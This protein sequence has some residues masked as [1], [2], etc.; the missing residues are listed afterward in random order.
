MN[1]LLVGL[2]L[3][4][5]GGFAHSATGTKM[6]CVGEEKETVIYVHLMVKDH[7]NLLTVR[8]V[9]KPNL[10]EV[11]FDYNE[12]GEVNE[13]EENYLI[14]TSLYDFEVKKV[15]DGPY[16]SGVL[17]APSFYQYHPVNVRCSMY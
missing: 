14:S 7:E 3:I 15:A 5:A 11:V 10:T 4:T 6:I 2:A 8:A 13:T 16:F 17:M 12:E 9:R 1:K